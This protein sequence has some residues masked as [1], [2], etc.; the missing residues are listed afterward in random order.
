MRQPKA[1]YLVNCV[2]MWECFSYYGM[3]AILLL[4]MT[5]SLNF[6]DAKALLIYTLYITFVELGGPLGGLLADRVLGL[7]RT[8]MIGGLTIALGHITLVSN[9]FI[10]LG[11]IVVGTALFRSNVATLLGSFYEGDDP[12][13]DAGFTLYYAGINLGGFLAALSCGA[14]GELYGWHWGFSLAAIGMC[15]G[16][17]LFILFSSLL[18]EKGKGVLPKEKSSFHLEG[19][20]LFG[21]FLLLLILFYACEEQIGSSLVFFADRFV[22]RT[23]GSFTVPATTIV[24]VNPLTI[25]LLGPLLA[26]FVKISAEQKMAVA[27]TLLA[28]A[29]LTLYGAFSEALPLSLLLFAYV[30]IA[31]AELFVG[32]TVYAMAA[33]LSTPRTAGVMMGI[34]TMCYSFA[35]FISGS[36][37]QGMVVDY[38]TSFFV[39]GTS[40][41]LIV[42]LIYFTMIRKRGYEQNPILD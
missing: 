39:I 38:A 34:V 5:E 33:K 18:G 35:S 15:F 10:G 28:V 29:F 31:T 40:A 7:R 16:L 41:M 42:C 37:A 22:D 9:L 6:S 23:I 27:F 17:T 11:L 2:S 1:L 25:L 19:G 13:R 30:L 12:R 36:I 32:P 26:R 20:W 21:G 4:Y 24:M 3:R 8:I 14:V